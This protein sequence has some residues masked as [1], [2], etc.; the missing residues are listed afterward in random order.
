MLRALRPSRACA[1]R[2]LPAAAPFPACAFAQKC[3]RSAHQRRWQH[4]E[5]AP[6]AAEQSA[7]SADRQHA[8]GVLIKG[9]F[10]AWVT[11]QSYRL[12]S[13]SAITLDPN[14]RL[15][16][17]RH[18]EHVATGIGRI[19]RWHT[20]DAAMEHLVSRDGV[21]KVVK[22]LGVVE[23][24]ARL[25][26]IELLARLAPYADAKQ[27]LRRADALARANESCAGR[28]KCTSAAPSERILARILASLHTHCSRRFAQVCQLTIRRSAALRSGRRWRR[29]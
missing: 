18:R 25:Q 26:A 14:L 27:R 11:Y 6:P 13:D 29:L 2:L 16:D 22:A 12:A 20:S 5:P 23:D 8:L 10:F 4:Q 17:S 28:R 19:H 3:Q 9:A 15:L 24:D 21:E 7:A 1:A